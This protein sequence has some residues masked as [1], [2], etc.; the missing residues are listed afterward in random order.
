MYLATFE[1]KTRPKFRS[2]LLKFFY[3]MS[4]L[5]MPCICKK[6]S[7]LDPVK[8]RLGLTVTN[9]LAYYTMFWFGIVQKMFYS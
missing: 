8:M 7:L 2:V 5:Y 6:G 3:H 4:V 9:T 1:L